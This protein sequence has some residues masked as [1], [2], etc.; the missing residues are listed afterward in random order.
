MN[1]LRS[2][3]EA[4]HI[5]SAITSSEGYEAVQARWNRNQKYSQTESK[6]WQKKKQKKQTLQ[7]MK[8]FKVFGTPLRWSRIYWQCWNSWWIFTSSNCNNWIISEH[9]YTVCIM[10][11]YMLLIWKKKVL[12]GCTNMNKNWLMN[13]ADGEI[14]ISYFFSQCGNSRILYVKQRYDCKQWSDLFFLNINGRNA[15]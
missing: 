12:C 7:V 5:S 10:T 15:V 4:K 2:S 8:R 1:I 6:L 14:Y 13:F 9:N 11:M 3:T